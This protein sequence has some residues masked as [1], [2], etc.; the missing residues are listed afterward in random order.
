MTKQN[1]QTPEKLKGVR[2]LFAAATYSFAG[3]MRMISEPAFRQECLLYVCILISFAVFSVPLSNYMVATALFLLLAAVETLNTAIEE[4]VNRV[5]PEIS[6]FA[7]VTKDLGSFA[8]FTMIS[9]NCLFALY[10]IVTVLLSAP[11]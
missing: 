4:I 9:L 1:Q 3:F 8:V 2:H 10:S 7:K 5:S 6:E 11:L